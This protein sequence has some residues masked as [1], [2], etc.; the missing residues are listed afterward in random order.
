MLGG[1]NLARG[2]L[3]WG[4]NVALGRQILLGGTKLKL[5]G[6]TKLLRRENMLWGITRGN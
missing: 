2:R 4:G 5:L 3:L 6:G 1:G